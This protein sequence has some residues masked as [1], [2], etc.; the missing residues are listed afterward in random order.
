MIAYEL[1]GNR[2]KALQSLEAAIRAHYS[3]EEIKNEPEL[4]SLRA[5]KRYYDILSVAH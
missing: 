2:D 5:D 3:L 4:T 1:A